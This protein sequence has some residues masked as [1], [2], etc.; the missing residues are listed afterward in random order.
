VRQIACFS[1]EDPPIIAL[2]TRD[3]S[4]DG[5]AVEPSPDLPRAGRVH[6]V[7][8]SEGAGDSL[9]VWAQLV[10]SDRESMALRFDLPEDAVLRRRLATFVEGLG[11]ST[12]G[13]QPGS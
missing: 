1:L 3:L 9:L 7:F 10:R 5:I 8:A 11:A 6:L 12:P 4:L 2:R 13:L